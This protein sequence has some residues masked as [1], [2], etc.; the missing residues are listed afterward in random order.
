M[1]TS[2]ASEFNANVIIVDD[3]LHRLDPVLT[4]VQ[5]LSAGSGGEP[6]GRG[7]GKALP[8]RLPSVRTLWYTG[9]QGCI[10]DSKWGLGG[11]AGGGAAENAL[12]HR[13]S[14]PSSYRPNPRTGCLL[15]DYSDDSGVKR[16][17]Q[18]GSPPL[19]RQALDL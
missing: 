11:F 5:P 2:C 8:P 3:V 7:G 19:P 16:R 15:L 4:G 10:A 14:P 12:R 17:F 13:P 6:E 18:A 1:Q 9:V